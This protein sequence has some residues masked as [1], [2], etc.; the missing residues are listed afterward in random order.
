MREEDD[1]VELTI[2]GRNI[3]IHLH[4][5]GTVESHDYMFQVFGSASELARVLVD[6]M[7]TV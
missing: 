3:P 4:E 6:Q 1:G 5:D 2:D 7:P